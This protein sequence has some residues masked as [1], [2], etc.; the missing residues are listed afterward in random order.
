MKFV[1]RIKEF[2]TKMFSSKKLLNEGSVE[3]TSS[4]KIKESIDTEVEKNKTVSNGSTQYRELI[5]L[6]K[7]Y[8]QGKIKET[9]MTSDQVFALESLFDSQIENARRKN[10]LTKKKILKA[11][12]EDQET[13]DIFAKIKRGDLEK[14]QLTDDQILQIEFLYDIEKT[15]INEIKKAKSAV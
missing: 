7:L 15:Q 1:E 11:L 8:L 9:D 6:Q 3:I 10:E 4:E 13:M 12:S 5:E 14:G 2:F